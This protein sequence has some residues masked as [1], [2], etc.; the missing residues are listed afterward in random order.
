M[1]PRLIL[2]GGPAYNQFVEARVMARAA[3]AQGVP[4]SAI[5]EE[6]EALDTIQNARFSAR[7]LKA[8][9]WRSAEVVSSSSHL[10]RAALIFGRIDLDWRVHA[11]PPLAPESAAWHAAVEAAETLKTTRYLLWTR[12]TEQ[13]EP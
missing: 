8:H 6:P 5:Y 13:W 3:Q 11:A 4:A 9:G 2:T 12:W 7:I 10:R 1:A